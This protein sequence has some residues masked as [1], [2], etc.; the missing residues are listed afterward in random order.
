MSKRW[1]V[2]VLAAAL[3]LSAC[4]ESPPPRA[5]YR[6]SYPVAPAPRFQEVIAYPARG[7]T[8]EQL[9]RDRYECHRWA[10]Q[11]TGFDPAQLPGAPQG[12]AVAQEPVPGSGLA[13]G[14]IAGA[15]LGSII[16]P[17][18][19]EGGGAVVGAITGGAI[20]AATERCRAGRCAARSSDGAVIWRRLSRGT[21]GRI[22]ASHERVPRRARLFGEIMDAIKRYLHG[23]SPAGAALLSV[24]T[25]HADPRHHDGPRGGEMREQRGFPP[26]GSFAASVPRGAYEVH[27]GGGR[28]WYHGGNWYGPRGGGWAIIAPPWED[29]RPGAAWL[30]FHDVVWR[31]ALLLRQ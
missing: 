2:T 9:D 4:V 23:S 24:G 10:A 20:G 3:T 12:Q 21:R 26:R 13:V 22:S 27:H 28:Y 25:I 5:Y 17:R 29:L 14:A 30:L 16:A 1:I 11:Q 31:H 18:G 8:P 19:S 6:H 15:V 7:Q